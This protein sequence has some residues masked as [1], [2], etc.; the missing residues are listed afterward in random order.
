ML[1]MIKKHFSI[2]IL[3][4]FSCVEHQFTF[5][6]SPDGS[7]QVE[8]KAHGDRS[9]LVDIDFPLPPEGNG[10]SIPLWKM[11]KQNCMITP[12]IGF[13]SEMKISQF[14]SIPGIQSIL[15]LC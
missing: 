3:L 15:S 5:T 1:N 10:L 7:Y 12:L 4:I 13:F 9:D 14:H 2:L 11:P 6:V 8:Y